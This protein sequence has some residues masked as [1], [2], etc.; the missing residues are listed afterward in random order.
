MH[1]TKIRQRLAVCAVAALFALTACTSGGGDTKGDARPDDGGAFAPAPA[2]ASCQEHQTRVP[3]TDYTSAEEGDTGKV[4]ELLRHYTAHGLKPYCDGRPP[5]A[6][7]RTWAKL[8]L[9]FGAD[10]GLI[11]PDLGGSAQPPGEPMEAPE[12]APAD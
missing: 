10:A 11:A 4:F 6:L 12:A 9:G 7:D 8:F 3:G 5:T 2:S 1:T